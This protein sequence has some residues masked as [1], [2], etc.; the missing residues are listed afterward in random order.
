MT[1]GTRNPVSGN[2][3]IFDHHEKTDYRAD[4]ALA[5][6]KA[7]KPAFKKSK[8]PQNDTGCHTADLQQL[9]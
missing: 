3:S 1:C 8:K 6:I 7:V 2:C 5:F 9:S 4:L